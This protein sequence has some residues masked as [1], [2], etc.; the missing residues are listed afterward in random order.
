MKIRLPF[1]FFPEKFKHF[2]FIWVI[3][4]TI[5]L[6][7][8]LQMPFHAAWIG[9]VSVAILAFAFRQAL[10]D[11]ERRF[12]Y[13]L[14]QI[15]SV[16]VLGYVYTPSFLYFGFYCIMAIGMLSTVRKVSFA[17]AYMVAAFGLTI[18][19]FY[20]KV[21]EALQF[22]FVPTLIILAVLPF[23]MRSQRKAEELRKQLRH[24]N[25]EIE[26]LI[27]NEERQRIA[28]DLHDTLGHTLS[29]ITLKG[30]L[31]ERLIPH[32]PERAVQEARDIQTTSRTVLKQVRELISDMRA[33]HL[34]DELRQAGEILS[35]AGIGFETA[36]DAERI[37]TTP[38]VMNILSMC[39]REAV[40]NV[41]KHSR[42]KHCKV[43][44][45]EKSGSYVLKVHDDGVGIDGAGSKLGQ[46]GSGLLGMKERLSL[47]EGTLEFSKQEET[48]TMLTITVPNVVKRQQTEGN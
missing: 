35:S 16:A 31:V 17:V 18:Y 46:T 38:V 25:D 7:Y 41:V 22:D 27:K 23:A 12:V 40:T 26:R 2:G 19:L 34:A 45:M 28:R 32:D 14:V 42:A 6:Y 30:E 3:N 33:V 10:W 9:Y 15:T 36:G 11:R 8:L 37:R 44:L 5:P 39:L 48:G 29:L 1:R 13:A 43:E 21:G 4:L 24:A 20:E 47:I